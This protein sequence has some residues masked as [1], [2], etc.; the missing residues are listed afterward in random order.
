MNRKK[1]VVVGALGVMGRYIVDRLAALPDWEVI[2]ISR[3][4]GTDRPRV[5]YVSADLLAPYTPDFDGATHV[6]YAAFQA[7]AGKA[8]D[9]ASNI[10]P[11]RDMLVHAVSAIERVSPALERVVLI[12]GTKY[13]GTHLGPYRTPA[14]E[15]DPR[16]P[17][18]NYYFDQIDW[19]TGFQRGKR[20]TW[21]ELRPQTLCGFAPGTAMSIVPVIAVYAA[22]MKELGRPFAWPGKPGSG[23]SIYQVTDSGHFADAALWAATDARCANQ[24]YNITNGDYFRWR[25]IWPALGQVFGMDCGEPAPLSLTAFMAD[26]APLWDAM[27]KKY[28]LKPHRFDEVVAWPFG[29]Y[30]F[31]TTWDV[32]SNLTKS[33]QHGFHAVVDSEAMFVRLLTQFRRERIVP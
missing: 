7:S 24:A 3:R 8:A 6:F 28:A 4:Q 26:K 29:D 19:L 13:Y 23:T 22:M 11:N 18:Q 21:A 31:N 15:S 1:A 14:R 25:D 20:W 16:H 30:V 2:G 32:M 9:Y 27:V 17:G 12:T 5:R 10:A 33:R